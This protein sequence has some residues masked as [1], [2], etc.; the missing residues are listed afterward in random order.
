MIGSIWLTGLTID[1]Q[2]LVYGFF[3]NMVMDRYLN[4]ARAWFLK[5]VSVRLYALG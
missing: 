2:N 5:V 1:Q 3:Y 4:Q